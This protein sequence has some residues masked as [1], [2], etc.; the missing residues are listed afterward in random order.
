MGGGEAS[1]FS[2]QDQRFFN[3]FLVSHGTLLGV[4]NLRVIPIQNYSKRIF[5]FSIPRAHSLTGNS[6]VRASCHNIYYPDLK[7]YRVRAMRA[8][9]KEPLS[10]WQKKYFS[11][12]YTKIKCKIYIRP[13][14]C[15]ESSWSIFNPYPHQFCKKILRE[16]K[17]T[18]GKRT[19]CLVH[20]SFRYTSTI[21]VIFGFML[22]DIT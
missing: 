7:Y 22:P 5:V 16:V 12:Q 9:T 15:R 20:I 2:M 13:F 17:Q 11:H 14:L 18:R 19:F 21:Y 1:V 3:L 10:L 8:T 6:G 4:K